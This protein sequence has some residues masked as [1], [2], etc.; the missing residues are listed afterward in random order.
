MNRIDE[1]FRELKSKNKKALI[2]YLAAGDPDIETTV[3]L[4][5]EMESKGAD[6]IEIGIPFSDPIAEGPVIQKAH[7]RALAQKI[8]ISDIMNAVEKIR[9]SVKVPLI[10][11]VYFNCILQYGVEKFFCD[12]SKTGIDGVIIPDLPF[13]E[14][15]EVDE[16]SNEYDVHVITLVSPT[17]EKRLSSMLETSKGFIYCITSLGVTGMRSEFS[18]DFKSF[19]EAVNEYTDLPKAL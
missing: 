3:M 4:V 15:W 8:K 9:E 19:M 18:T 7:G 17:S 6:I 1:K 12:C 14:R 10:Y 5:R 13:E 2:T 16:A 11:M